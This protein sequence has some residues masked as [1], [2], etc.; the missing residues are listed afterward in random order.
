ML[1]HGSFAVGE[2]FRKQE[3]KEEILLA[4]S[5]FDFVCKRAL[6]LSFFFSA[7]LSYFRFFVFQNQF[8]E[9]TFLVLSFFL[10]FKPVLL[11]CLV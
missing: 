10:S 2:K 3:A 5:V 9:E 1:K 7:C 8:Q 4:N 11:F 6:F